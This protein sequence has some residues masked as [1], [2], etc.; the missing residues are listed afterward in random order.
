MVVQSLA[1]LRER[2]EVKE[3][4]A[5]RLFALSLFYIFVPFAALIVEHVVG[6]APLGAWM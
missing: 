6:L 3:P 1:V 5:H 4:A 2:D